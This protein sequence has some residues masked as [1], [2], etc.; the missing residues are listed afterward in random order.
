MGEL[1]VPVTEFLTKEKIGENNDNYPAQKGKQLIDRS[2][3]QEAKCFGSIKSGIKSIATAVT[4][5]GKT[6]DQKHILNQ[7][8]RIT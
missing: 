4:Q 5:N 6:K 3:H 8:S 7:N 2:R 1:E